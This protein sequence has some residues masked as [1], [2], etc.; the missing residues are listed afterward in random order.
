MPHE[1]VTIKNNPKSLEEQEEM[2]F[3][4]LSGIQMFYCLRV[5]EGKTPI[6][7]KEE[8]AG[9]VFNTEKGLSAFKNTLKTYSNIGLEIYMSYAAKIGS[10]LTFSRPYEIEEY[11]KHD[12][13]FASYEDAIFKDIFKSYESMG[14]NR[15]LKTNINTWLDSAYQTINRHAQQLPRSIKNQFMVYAE[16]LAAKRHKERFRKF[17]PISYDILRFGAHS[18]KMSEYGITENASVARLHFA[19]FFK[20]KTSAQDSVMATTFDALKKL[21]ADLSVRHPEVK[22]IVA[23]SWLLDSPAAKPLRFH[24]LKNNTPEFQAGSF[25]GQFITKDGKINNDRVNDFLKTGKPPFQIKK[26][27]IPIQEFNK[28][29]LV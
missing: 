20:E 7:Q 10:P 12:T 28:M 26:G 11:K 14:G 18:A 4:H 6:I 22:G 5:Y 9:S 13:D 1:R 3:A 21:A 16:K 25:W 24:L 17:G 19:L 27:F 2:L 8:N 29:F 23:E 15:L